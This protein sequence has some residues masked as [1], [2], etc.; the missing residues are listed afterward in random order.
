MTPSPRV[1][2]LTTADPQEML[3]LLGDQASPRK[4][5]LFACACVRKVERLLTD[6]VSRDTLALAERHAEG[7][8][9]L[10]ELLAQGD[11]AELVASG[12]ATRL[13]DADFLMGVAAIQDA[14]LSAAFAAFNCTLTSAWRAADYCSANASSAAFHAATA[15]GNLPAAGQREAVRAEQCRFL[16]E[17]FGD[18]WSG[19]R[20]R[21]E[22]LA[23]NDHTVERLAQAIAQEQAFDRLP[24]L[25]DAL[26]DAG[27]D[28]SLLLDHCRSKAGHLRGCWALDQL[29]SVGSFR[30]ADQ[31]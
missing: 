19:V 4:L 11:R 5:R 16:R 8:V 31:I 26:E 10:A 30:G 17:I 20:V 1:L 18:P 6:P 2:W 21:P 9:S 24:I 13:S 7:A 25:A 12:L 27:C 29:L 15:D 28:Q 23:W 14:E 22:W 3:R